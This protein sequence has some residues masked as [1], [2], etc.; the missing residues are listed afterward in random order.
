MRYLAIAIW[1]L[2]EA[3]NLATRIRE[4]CQD[5]DTLF[6]MGRAFLQAKY[7]YAGTET[8]ATILGKLCPCIREA[9]LRLTGGVSN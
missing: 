8:V 9:V 2:I 3:L 5:V 6:E 1:K 7:S 4:V